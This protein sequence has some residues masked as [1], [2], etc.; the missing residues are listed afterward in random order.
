MQQSTFQNFSTVDAQDSGPNK[1][2]ASIF[3]SGMPL[4]LIMCNTEPGV[5][6]GAKASINRKE[7]IAIRAEILKQNARMVK[8][9]GF[10]KNNLEDSVAKIDEWRDSS[11]FGLQL[12]K[13]CPLKQWSGLNRALQALQP[14]F[15]TFRGRACKNCKRADRYDEQD[16]R[17]KHRWKVS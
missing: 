4:Q 3:A 14:L 15:A 17:S 11:I 6:I 16:F 1:I 8:E 2:Y 9:R 10:V 13:D 5:H 7:N 12:P